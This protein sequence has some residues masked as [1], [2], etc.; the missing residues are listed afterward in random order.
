MTFLYMVIDTFVAKT[1]N[2][3]QPYVRRPRKHDW[4][5]LEGEKAVTDSE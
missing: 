5:Y 3:A 2:V 4:F 1:A